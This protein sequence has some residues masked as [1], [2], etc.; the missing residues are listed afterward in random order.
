MRDVDLNNPAEE[1]V[2]K[3][4]RSFYPLQSMEKNINLPESRI[5]NGGI[6]KTVGDK[7]YYDLGDVPFIKD[8]FSTRIY[9]SNILQQS[10]FVN[11]NRTFLAKNYQD[12][13]MEYG[14]LVKLIE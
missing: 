5:I 10:T 11:G 1:A 13:S 4:K 9:Y 7:Y 14:A 12:Y 2:F 6:S 8:T 3:M